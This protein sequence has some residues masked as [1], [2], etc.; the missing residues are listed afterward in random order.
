MGK[1][2][3]KTLPYGGFVAGYRLTGPYPDPYRRWEKSKALNADR[4]GH[5]VCQS[6]PAATGAG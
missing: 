6:A 1:G 2:R 4:Q 3:M 5:L